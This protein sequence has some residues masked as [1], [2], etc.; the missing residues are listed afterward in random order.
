MDVFGP[1]EGG[2]MATVGPLPLL[3][4]AGGVVWTVVSSQAARAST[5]NTA[6][7][8]IVRRFMDFSFS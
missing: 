4:G 5:S 6:M 2:S 3:T 1:T 7:S 8:T